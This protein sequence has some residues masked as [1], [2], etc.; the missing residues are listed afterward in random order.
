MQSDWDVIVAGGGL[1]GLTA[2]ATATQEGARVLVLEA[3]GTGGRART[4]DRDG[5][6]FN[7]GGHALYRGGAGMSVLHS[8]GITPEGAPP[9][10]ARY[11]ALS[12][13]RH[14]RL[15]S[16]PTSLLRSGALTRRSKVQLARTLARLPR[17]QP[18]D[19][20]G[21]SVADWLERAR[22][23]PDARAV[24][25]AL[26]RLSTY[27]ADVDEFSAGAAIG[28][29]QVAANGG[30]LYLHGGW[31]Q[32]VD[33]LATG[34][35]VRSGVAVTGVQPTSGGLSVRTS[36]G[37]L[38]A[39]R[40][41]VATGAPPAV[42]RVLP[43]DPGWGELGPPVT[44]ACLDVGVSEPPEPGYLLSLEEPLYATVQSPPARQAPDG[45]AVMAVIR[46]GARSAEQDR[47]QLEDHLT[48][49]GVRPGT[50][51]TSRMLARLTVAGTLPRAGSG[52]LGGRPP[53]IRLRYARGGHRRRLGRWDW[54]PGRRGDGQWSRRRPG[55]RAATSLIA[56]DGWVISDDRA[57]TARFE[58]E[59]PRLTG[60]A[61]RM[62]GTVSDAED[63]VQETWLRWQRQPVDTIERPE[64]WLTTVTTRISLDHLRAAR[65]RRE[66]YVGPWLPEPLVSDPGPAETA[67]LADSL[68]LGFLTLLDQL[69][70]TECAVFLLADVF[71]VPFADIAPTVGKSEAACRQIA[72]RA[73]QR[74]RR[75]AVGR[76]GTAPPRRARQQVVDELLE[77]VV[78]GDID[79]VVTCLTPDAVC[80]S[81]GGAEVRAAR[82]PVTGAP[83]VARFL[84]NLAH[85]YPDRVAVRPVS[86]NGDIGAVITVDAR[87]DLVTAFEVDGDRVAAIRM[88]RNPD[89]LT[90]VEA[91]ATLE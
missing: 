44:A 52:G 49:A 84:V 67:E 48:A 81:D 40:V 23:R 17:L 77:A 32:L 31:V 61:Y 90:R 37:S 50:V 42:R 14:H 85:R 47:P 88:I 19:L 25:E 3:H 41:V 55:C 89:K 64:A 10:L 38:L 74:V 66:S 1:A 16:G 21:T 60:L 22:L 68:R 5:Y 35:D 29:L 56:Q 11:E 62:L 30:V 20:A 57:A 12:G 8:L 72:S 82:R 76:P 63:V 15:P 39:R 54:T 6:L 26:I 75:P 87:V 34:L 71:G 53:G 27:S 24:V 83:R 59:R 70:P 2:A 51:V 73:R 80:I 46:Y 91:P 79:R 4:V 13:G 7:M 45:H 69:Q 9:P 43:D 18:T 28:Q 78:V 58:H 65:R 36:E 86:V 33:A